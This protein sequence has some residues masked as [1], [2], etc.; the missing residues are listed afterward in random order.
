MLAQA[1]WAFKISSTELCTYFLYSEVRQFPSCSTIS[2]WTPA[3]TAD[4][5]PPLRRE[6]PFHS[7]WGILGNILPS[8]VRK[9]FTSIDLVTGFPSD[10]IKNG[11]C[12]ER[13]PTR[14][15]L[16]ECR[17]LHGSTGFPLIL[18]INFLMTGAVFVLWRVTSTYEGWKIM[19]WFLIKTI[20]P[21]LTDAQTSFIRQH[22][23][24]PIAVMAEKRRLF[25]WLKS[26][27]CTRVLRI[28]TVIGR[29][30][31]LL[32]GGLPLTMALSVEWIYHEPRG[33]KNGGP[34][35]RLTCADNEY[36]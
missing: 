16:K 22:P 21:R 1:R 7:F 33:I 23:K 10:E 13:E 9:N 8:S 27:L 2:L 19:S 5:A 6:A 25:P 30:K 34:P 28:G 31:T 12:L 3:W 24:T 32:A 11:P 18:A 15:H 26:I 20:F 29:R 36:K 35:R 4:E 17:S 14:E